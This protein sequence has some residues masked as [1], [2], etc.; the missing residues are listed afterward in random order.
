MTHNLPTSQPT[1]QTVLHDTI[2]NSECTTGLLKSQLAGNM[3]PKAQCYV[4][5][6]THSSQETCCPQQCYVTHS[7]HV[8]ENSKTVVL[9][10]PRP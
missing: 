9:S 10:L 4:T 6:S 5:H 3:L 1:S 7:T 2:C 8:C